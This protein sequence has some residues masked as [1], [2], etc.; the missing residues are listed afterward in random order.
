MNAELNSH[1]Q[2]LAFAIEKH[3]FEVLSCLDHK[4]VVKPLIFINWQGTGGKLGYVTL[5]KRYGLTVSQVRTICAS[6]KKPCEKP[7]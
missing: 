1:I 5:A 4:E 2:S 7:A 6:F 3:G